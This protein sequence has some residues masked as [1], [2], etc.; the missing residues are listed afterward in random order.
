MSDML[1]YSDF[2]S[3]YTNNGIREINPGVELAKVEK[4]NLLA[5]FSG[6]GST[7][8]GQHSCRPK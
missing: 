6:A 2:G 5:D 3:F 8:T 4:Q 1:E 7:F